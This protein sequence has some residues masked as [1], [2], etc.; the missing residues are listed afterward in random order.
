[1][2]QIGVREPSLGPVGRHLFGG[3]SLIAA[4]G[5]VIWAV[6]NG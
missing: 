3:L 2:S 1:M 5:V 6:A 4:L